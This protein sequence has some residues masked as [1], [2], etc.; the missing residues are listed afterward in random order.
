[1]T[2]N[3]LRIGLLAALSLMAMPPAARGQAAPAATAPA[4][5]PVPDAVFRAVVGRQ[6][7]LRMVDGQTLTG[8]LLNLEADNAVVALPDGRVTAVPRAQVLD[9]RLSAAAAP[10]TA[11]APAPADVPKAEEK[12]DENKEAARVPDVE[13]VDRHFGLQFGLG[14]GVLVADLAY[15]AFYGFLSGSLALPMYSAGTSNNLGGVTL[16]PGLSF[17]M[18]TDRNWRFDLFVSASLGYYGHNDYSWDGS[19]NRWTSVDGSVGVGI[20]F[21]YTAQSGLTAGFKVPVLGFAFGRDVNS[22]KTSGLYHY[23][24][25]LVSYPVATIGYRF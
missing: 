15:G 12:K 16:A 22:L 1:M 5:A 17:K 4:S 11:P 19:E 23:L 8:Q 20:G 21:H 6:V 25:T 7:E 14:P 2:K 24:N 18:A 3:A 13:P 9:V 10:A